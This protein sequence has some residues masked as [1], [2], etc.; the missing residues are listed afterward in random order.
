[1][2]NKEKG[3]KKGLKKALKRV[4]DDPR[5]GLSNKNRAI[6]V[7]ACTTLETGDDEAF[8]QASDNEAFMQAINQGREQHKAESDRDVD[9]TYDYIINKVKEFKKVGGSGSA[10]VDR[11]PYHMK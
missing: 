5:G 4:L 7:R 2:D 10:K 1:M 9:E 6:I 11:P 8:I 3:L